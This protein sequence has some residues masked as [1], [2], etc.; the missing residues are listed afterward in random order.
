[1]YVNIYIYAFIHTYRKRASLCLI[2]I[3]YTVGTHLGKKY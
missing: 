2:H 3:R 1:M